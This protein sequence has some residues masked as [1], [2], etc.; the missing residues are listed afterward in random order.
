[1]SEN[2]DRKQCKCGKSKE[3]PFCDGSHKV[4]NVDF[5]KEEVTDKDFKIFM[6]AFLGS[7]KGS[8]YNPE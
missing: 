3:H 4:K 6:D 5:H 8:T 2:Q 1:M 7:Y